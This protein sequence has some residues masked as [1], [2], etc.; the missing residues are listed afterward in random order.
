MSAVKHSR[1]R[2][3]DTPDPEAEARLG[4]LRKGEEVQRGWGKRRVHAGYSGV[5]GGQ[6]AGPR[7]VFEV[8][9]KDSGFYILSDTGNY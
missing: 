4:C 3:E 1:Q 7:R 6:V 5:S 8:H 2:R 9:K